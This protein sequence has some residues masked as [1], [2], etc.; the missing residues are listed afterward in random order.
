MSGEKHVVNNYRPI[1]LLPNFR[2]NFKKVIYRSMLNYVEKNKILSSC[3]YGF[4]K[5][6]STSCAVLD[7]FKYLHDSFDDGIFFQFS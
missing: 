7:H 5:K 2:K 1:S 3:Q 4:R 6:W